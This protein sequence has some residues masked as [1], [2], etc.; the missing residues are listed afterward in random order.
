MTARKIFLRMLDLY[1]FKGIE[2]RLHRKNDLGG[3]FIR[4]D[5]ANVKVFL[6]YAEIAKFMQSADWNLIPDHFAPEREE[7]RASGRDALLLTASEYSGE[8]GLWYQSLC[9]LF[10]VEYDAGRTKITDPAIKETLQQIEK[11]ALLEM[12]DKIPDGRKKRGGARKPEARDKDCT[13]NPNPWNFEIPGPR[14]FRDLLKAYRSNEGSAKAL[15]PLTENCGNRTLRFPPETYQFMNQMIMKHL[16]TKRAKPFKVAKLVLDEFAHENDRR[17]VEGESPLVV[18]S[19]WTIPK[20]VE[21]ISPYHKSVK[22]YG[23]DVANL[24]FRLR[25]D[26]FDVLYPLQRVEGDDWEGDVF[27]LAIRTNLANVF[28]KKQLARVPRTRRIVTLAVDCATRVV[29]GVKVSAK[30]H[31]SNSIAVL[32][33]ILRDKTE[34]AQSYGAESKWDFYGRPGLIVCDNG[35]PFVAA[36]FRRAVEDLGSNLR[37]EVGGLPDNRPYVE[38]IFNTFTTGFMPLLSARTHSNVVEKGNADPKSEAVLTDDELTAAMAIFIADVYHNS[39]HSGLNGATPANTWKKLCE[40]FGYPAEV[41]HLTRTAAVGIP[42]KCKVSGGQVRFAGLDYYCDKLK[43]ISLDVADAEVEIRIDPA[44]LGHVTVWYEKKPYLAICATPGF[45]NI[46]YEDWKRE[47]KEL[48]QSNRAESELSLPVVRRGIRKIRDMDD[49]GRRRAGFG[50]E[51]TSA[52]ELEYDKKSLFYGFSIQRGDKDTPSV[53]E[54]TGFLSDV[55]EPIGPPVEDLTSPEKSEKSP[56]EV[57]MPPKP[58]K[59]W[60]IADD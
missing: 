28:T 25:E 11:H 29:V 12:R 31:S 23:R 33:Q 35:P 43:Q 40:E 41:P 14:R 21:K 27:S 10:M 44:D 56:E 3:E 24:E 17:V 50:M 45:E 37:T 6:T 47:F 60:G 59:G 39:P 22:A 1:V 38:R 30:P 19:Y 42:T 13:A 26:G 48:V 34:F 15:R 32:D 46:S 54:D 36:R 55:I 9:R 7:L 16:N 58:S 8:T 2:Y 49:F 18:P 51:E 52:D 5:L 20:Y 53:P 4:L 57:S